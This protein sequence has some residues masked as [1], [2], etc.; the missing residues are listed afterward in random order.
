MEI[1]L[2]WL[3]EI[4]LA[5]VT[6][7]AIA[8]CKY[9]HSRSKKLESL[10]QDKTQEEIVA[11]VQEE[12]KPIIAEIHRLQSELK[13]FQDQ[14]HREIEAIVN[15]YKFRLV[16]LCTKYMKQGYITSGQFEQLSEFYKVYISLGGNGQAQAYYAK[17]LNLPM[18]EHIEVLEGGQ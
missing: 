1:V 2:S 4:M 6:C 8:L 15:S 12:V 17:V 10:L 3:T 16:Q 11:L 14:E 18:R 7:G 13:D 9:F 5:V